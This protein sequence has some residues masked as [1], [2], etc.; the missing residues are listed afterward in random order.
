[1]SHVNAARAMG[2]TLARAGVTLVYGGGAVG[3][4]GIV[5]DSAMA[6]GGT[7]VGVIPKALADLEVAHHGLTRLHIVGSMHERKAMMADLSD[8]FIAMAGGIGTLEELFEIWTWGQLGDHH[9]PVAMLN[10][11]GFFD[12]LIGFLD[13]TVDAGFFRPHHRG[14]L[15]VDDDPEQLVD[16]M[17]EYCPP[18]LGK[19]IDSD[20]R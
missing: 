4:M 12:S 3:L 7:V 18:S 13:Q 16:R 20:N 8:G 15:I 10:I 6:A 17:R 5:A 11:D 14:M 9:K 19:W 2:T 1:L